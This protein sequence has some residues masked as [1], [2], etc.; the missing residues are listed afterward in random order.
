MLDRPFISQMR[1]FVL[2]ICGSP[3]SRKEHVNIRH[4]CWANL[5][6]FAGK[7][8]LGVNLQEKVTNH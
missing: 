8:V 7:L 3:F 1:L 4:A 2:W 5:E 6:R